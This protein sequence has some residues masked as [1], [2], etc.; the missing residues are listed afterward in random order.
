[1]KNK[2]FNVWLFLC[3]FAFTATA[4]NEPDKGRPEVAD[5]FEELEE[6][7]VTAGGISREKK[8]LGF[9]VEEVEGASIKESG[10]TNIVSG[11][12]AKVS[13]VQVTNSSGAAG[14]A[15]YI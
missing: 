3:A 13:G 8:A 1:M 7:V 15:S 4:Q 10:E 11:I 2:F 6:V 12:S 9:S 14:A 5:V